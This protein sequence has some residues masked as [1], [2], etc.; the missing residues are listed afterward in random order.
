MKIRPIERTDNA[1]MEGV[2][3]E[4]LIE[5]GGN[6]EGLAWAD[7]SLHDLYSYYNSAANRASWIVEVDG[8]VLGGCG[9]AAFDEQ[10]QICELQKM[11]LSSAI[12]GKGVAADLLDTALAFA[13][14]HYRKCYLETLLTMQ[15]AGRFYAKHGFSLLDAPLGGSE[16]YACDAWYIRDL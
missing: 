12:R 7:D 10:E 2:I 6:R 14:R 11:Y 3:R 8:Y 15:A 1:A 16:H 13:R 9:I 5:F 4:C